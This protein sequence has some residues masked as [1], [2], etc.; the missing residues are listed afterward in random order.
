[1]T[2]ILQEPPFFIVG[3]GRSGTTLVRAKLAGHSRLTV[4]PETHYMARIAREDPASEAPAD[5]D[6][7]WARLTGWRRFLDLKIDPERVLAL[8]DA[9]GR[10]TYRT[11]FA[12]MLRAYGDAAGKPRVGEKTP[13][14]Y[15]HLDRLFAWVPQAK[16][17]AMRRDPRAVVASQIR[18]PWVSEQ[19]EAQGGSWLRRRRLFHVVE[20]AHLWEEAYQRYLARAETDP[21]MLIVAYEDL[22]ARPEAE[23]ARL[24]DFLGERFEPE[25]LDE[26]EDIPAAPVSGHSSTHSRT[27]AAEHRKRAAS[28]IDTQS[29]EKWRE[30][31]SAAEI[32]LV[33]EICAGGM[34]RFGYARSV[35]RPGA[36]ALGEGLLKLGGLE[37]RARRRLRSARR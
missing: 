33:E 24:C 18:S 10:R 15:R 4:P 25:M 5:F 22:V 23:M 3:H 7:F 6:T 29:L 31:L 37:T 8:A 9:G 16:I 28:G 19:M 12:A 35:H 34:A 2:D 20:Q 21:R 32:A 14:N 36:G 17:V 11:I 30:Q 1:M 26:R 13:G 27:W